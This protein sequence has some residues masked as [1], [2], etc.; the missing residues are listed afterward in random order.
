MRWH[1]FH[2]IPRLCW[3]RSFRGGVQGSSLLLGEWTLVLWLL[4]DLVYINSFFSAQNLTSLPLALKAVRM[5]SWRIDVCRGDEH[6]LMSLS[7]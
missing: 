1:G 6:L 5:E 2:L 3:L 7:R 4:V